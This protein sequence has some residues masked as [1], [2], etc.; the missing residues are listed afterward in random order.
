MAEAIT[1]NGA[2]KHAMANDFHQGGN[3]SAPRGGTNYGNVKHTLVDS[4]NHG[5]E[6]VKVKGAMAE[7][8]SAVSYYHGGKM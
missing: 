7:S 8:G 2:P 6:S 4:I 5:A 1:V 3:K